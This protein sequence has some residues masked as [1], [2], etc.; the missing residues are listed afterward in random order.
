MAKITKDTYIEWY[1]L[2]LRIRRFEE[3]AAQMYA[4]QKIRGFLHLYI[5]QEAIAAAVKSASEES[6]PVITAYR[7]HGLALMRGVTMK[8]G[9]AEL[10][11]KVT[12]CT[13]GK[14][15][16]MHFFHV[17]GRFYGGH[18]IVG[19]QIPLGAGLGF[20][21]KYKGTKNVSLTF[22]GDG[23][24]KQG[25][26]HETLNMAAFWKLPVIFLIENNHYA[27]GTSVERSGPVKD[28]HHMACAY[29]IKHEAVDAMHPLPV[30]KA[31]EKALK[32]CR[33]GKGPYVLE[34]KT[35]RYKGH[36]MSDPAKYR[37]REE[38]E[39][40]RKKDPISGVAH[41]LLEKGYLDEA[42]LK[43]IQDEVKSEVE[44]A[45]AFAESSPFPSPDALY[46]D[47]YVQADYPF[48][49]D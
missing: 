13:K 41:D 5:G 32:Q 7:D 28:L 18:G 48:I 47:N 12:G 11:G 17:A 27:M 33:A 43:N 29:N 36:S 34:L 3:K 20:A 15:G 37:T 1:R 6:D 9:M 30:H 21:E 40:Y 10:Y 22:L 49:K 8:E 26:W 46:E 44:E 25:S 38:L 35:Y 31:I 42:G 45:V 14:G 24:I 2:M 39:A 19:G 4:Q 23:A 16:S